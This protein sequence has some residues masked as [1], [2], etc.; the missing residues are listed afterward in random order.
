M[1]R[2]KRQTKDVNSMQGRTNTVLLMFALFIFM[3]GLCNL[4][5]GFFY[6]PPPTSSSTS[7]STRHSNSRNS[8]SN[9]HHGT[10]HNQ[11][12]HAVD[13]STAFTQHHDDQYNDNQNHVKQV[14]PPDA[15]HE[16]NNS[17]D[18]QLK[19]ATTTTKA[20]Q[21]ITDPNHKLPQWITNYFEW[22]A[23]MRSKFPGDEIFTNPDAPPV[24]I[25]K[26]LEGLCGG[27]HDRLGQLPMDLYLANQTKRMLFIAWLKPY[28]IEHFLVPPDA[29]LEGN[30]YSL[31]WQMPPY[32]K[33]GTKCAKRK[34]C[35]RH[36]VAL[37]QLDGNVV[38]QRKG[39]ASDKPVPQLIEESIYNLTEGI[40]KN[41][42]A[43]T[44]EILGHLQ[45]G[46]LEEKLRELGETDMIHNTPSFGKIFLSFFT[47]SPS[48]QAVIDQV[49]EELGLVSKRYTAVHCRVRHPFGYRKAQK[50]NGI[51]AGKADR[52]IPEFIGDFKDT[53]VGTAINAIKCAATK[54]AQDKMYFMSDMSDLIDYVAFNLT[55]TNYVSSH[56]EWFEDEKSVNVTAKNLVTRY[57][58]VAREQNTP[59]LHIDKAVLT[60]VED[61]YGA[62]VDLFLG[63]HAGCVAYGIGFYAA[64]AAKISGTKC[65]VKYANELYGGSKEKVT[66]DKSIRCNYKLAANM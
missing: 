19:A 11:Q 26:C 49:N 54:N 18:H 46:Y 9:R 29:S 12:R 3:T 41:E 58:V 35:L 65:V 31:D 14:N 61:Y 42:K 7:T 44:F 22:H 15:N 16:N 37:P 1:G 8:S 59:N 62:F 32:Q 36:F 24:L 63:I 5:L 50:F 52:Y 64:F 2:Q 17:F 38:G 6:S 40:Y 45:E 51:Y 55:D 60:D 33:Y 4:F 47:P 39:T 10:F 48:V 20:H 66:S 28:S 30:E 43:V 27:L 56:P 25:R 13:S 53:M 34:H 21:F 23:S 57:E